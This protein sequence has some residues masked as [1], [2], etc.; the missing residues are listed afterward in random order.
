MM[1]WLVFGIL[2]LSLWKNAAAVDLRFTDTGFSSDVL[3]R[4]HIRLLG[5]LPSPEVV[6]EINQDTVYNDFVDQLIASPAYNDALTR[7][8]TELLGITKGDDIEW[9]RRQVALNT[10]VDQ[11]LQGWFETREES[12]NSDEEAFARAKTLGPSLFGESMNCIHCHDH[13]YRRSRTRDFYGLAGF[14][15]RE[16]FVIRPDTVFGPDRELPRSAAT[17]GWVEPYIEI[18]SERRLER[19]VEKDRDIGNQRALHGFAEW[20]TDFRYNKFTEFSIVGRYLAHLTG[21][22][23]WRHLAERD[24]EV[25]ATRSRLGPWVQR[26]RNQ[27]HDEKELIRAVLIDPQFVDFSNDSEFAIP[28]KRNAT[29]WKEA[30]SQ[31][32]QIA[33]VSRYSEMKATTAIQ[34]H[35]VIDQIFDNEKEVSVIPPELLFLSALSRSPTSEE[36]ALVREA[37]TRELCH[38]LF[39][40]NEFCRIP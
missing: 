33:D 4:L 5:T 17:L 36:L 7:Y 28:S 15:K 37:D 24:Y 38:A 14:F 39:L 6:Q 20:L 35:L 27:R 40:S 13:A 26:F 30:V 22:E 23:N 19:V 21:N 29:E 31:V 34:R 25:D 10:P 16:G 9:M 32:L 11:R 2:S 18:H 1:R 8:W 3:R 12:V